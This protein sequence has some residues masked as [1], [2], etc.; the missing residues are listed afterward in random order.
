MI[1]YCEWVNISLNH[2]TTMCDKSYFF[3]TKDIDGEYNDF[4]VVCPYC[5]SKLKIKDTK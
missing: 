3:Q 1:K 4:P 5:G 2:F